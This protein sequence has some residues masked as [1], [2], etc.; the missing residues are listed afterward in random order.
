MTFFTTLWLATAT[1]TSTPPP[2]SDT[3]SG[4]SWTLPDWTTIFGPLPQILAD[5]GKQ[6][7]TM[8]TTFSD[9]ISGHFL[10]T[11]IDNLIIQWAD[12]SITPQLG[13]FQK[14]Y[15]FT[16]RIAEIGFVRTLWS[17]VTLLCVIALFVGIG[18]LTNQV[19]KG[20][21]EMKRL[22]I[23]FVVSL[24]TSIISLTVLN[25]IN[26]VLNWLTQMMLEGIIGTTGLDYTSISGQDMLKALTMGSTM[27]TDPA[28]AGMTLGE[29][30]TGV[31]GLFSMIVHIYLVFP[32]MY[33]LAT[34]KILTLIGMVIGV[35]FWISYVAF[36]GRLEVLIG[37]L[38]LYVRTLFVGV[39]MTLHWAIFVKAQTD[40]SMGEGV[41]AEMGVHPAIAAPVS[42]I[43]L[44]VLLYF[45]W[46]KPLWR[47][48][49][50]PITLNG[51]KVVERAGQWSE[52]ASTTMQAIGKR[53]G[54]EGIQKRGLNVASLA[55]KM[56]E[57]GKKMQESRSQMG[58]RM[59]STATRG[60]SEVLQGVRYE[61]P[62][63]WAEQTGD[64]VTAKAAPVSFV[65][66]QVMA[67]SH[68]ISHKLK[69]GGFEASTLI[70]VPQTERGD[71]RKMLALPDFK[72]KHGAA[73]TYKEA[74][75][76]LVASGSQGKAALNELRDAQFTVSD[77]AIGHAKE[78]V[79]VGHD[80]SVK[81]VAKG[82]GTEEAFKMVQEQLP[83]YTKANLSPEDATAAHRR[84]LADS[85]RYPWADKL[86]LR[87]DG[88]WVPEE[89]SKEVKPV[90]EGMQKHGVTRV[91]L[92]L[93]KGSR[94]LARMLQDWEDSNKHEEWLSTVE[95][96]EQKNRVVVPQE[97]LADFQAAYD[98][99]RKERTPYWRT[100]FGKIKVIL[101]GQPVDY[102][103]PPL[104]GLDMGSFE[105]LQKEMMR[106]QEAQR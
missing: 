28:Y 82:K 23:G 102:G 90:L 19:L 48:M 30:L 5:F 24:S 3:S 46:L 4:S 54:S 63:E 27:L 26:V 17:I 50:D 62:T 79:F 37:Y 59:L 13:V 99:Y 80:G 45:I 12:E 98:A 74:T 92:A 87:K 39:L 89:L 94:F 35:G 9:I 53:L 104:K 73:I 20:K 83:A 47:G 21:V 2:E 32:V 6:I 76:E 85:K 8:N 69:A 72:Q 43:A 78:G 65:G 103:Q 36:S 38:N 49:R 91:Q 105:D 77:A 96:D 61:G 57:S 70:K 101:D 100:T 25:L 51:G 14:I 7:D 88:L 18:V 16:P 42:V 1:P 60:V 41:W 33:L 71:L 31:G 52:K 34:I 66:A 95:A 75:G 68:E 22:L 29:A 15:L 86:K 67:E 40:Y 10:K 106:K 81:R 55:R 93:P 56:Q 84:L 44:L 58:K 64:I 11:S 97:K